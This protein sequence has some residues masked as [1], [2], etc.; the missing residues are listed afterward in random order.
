MENL[1]K[2]NEA[3]ILR[4]KEDIKNLAGFFEGNM[5]SFQFF[6]ESAMTLQLHNMMQ[7]DYK[8]PKPC[9]EEFK[10]LLHN[11]KVLNDMTSNLVKISDLNEEIRE[12][13]L[14][15]NNAN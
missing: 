13:K 6:I 10:M 3:L 11:I 9:I 8:S 4:L 15:L 1:I 5:Y 7:N 14:K 2:E 12:E